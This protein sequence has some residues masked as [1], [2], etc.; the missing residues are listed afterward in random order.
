[1]QVEVNVKTGRGVGVRQTSKNTWEA[2]RPNPIQKGAWLKISSHSGADAQAQAELAAAKDR[3][4]RTPTMEVPP[5]PAGMPARP[6]T[7]PPCAPFSDSVRCVAW[8]LAVAILDDTLPPLDNAWT[9]PVFEPTQEETE[10][11]RRLADKCRECGLDVLLPFVPLVERS[12]LRDR[13]P[14]Q[15]LRG[16]GGRMVLATRGA[17]AHGR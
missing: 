13:Q 1:M 11:R 7:M 5:Q 15:P 17:R 6:R 12:L 4:C 9:P 2:R 3:Q 8:P 16:V 10:A 14:L